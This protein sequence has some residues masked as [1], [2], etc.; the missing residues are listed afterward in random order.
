MLHLPFWQHWVYLGRGQT[1]CRRRRALWKEMSVKNVLYMFY[2]TFSRPFHQVG[3][4]KK[5]W[6]KN[7]SGI[8]TELW[9]WSNPEMIKDNSKELTM[10]ARKGPSKRRGDKCKRT[11]LT[12]ECLIK[13]ELW[14]VS[15][16]NQNT[17]H[18][19]N[20]PKDRVRVGV[21]AEQTG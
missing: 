21:G 8:F 11:R 19:Y 10:S 3:N 7:K 14:S 5:K 20:Q 1:G 17:V 13:T 4:S 18:R 15:L 16:N 12:V 6:G 2:M 9:H